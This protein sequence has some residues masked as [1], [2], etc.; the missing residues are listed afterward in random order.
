M[1]KNNERLLDYDFGKKQIN[2]DFKNM[3]ITTDNQSIL[4]VNS[5]TTPQGFELWHLRNGSSSLQYSVYAKSS[6]NT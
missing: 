5:E 1:M 4:R 2:E 3:E 6:M